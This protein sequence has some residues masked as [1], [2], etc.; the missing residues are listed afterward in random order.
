M[1]P[2][3][4]ATACSVLEQFTGSITNNDP[5]HFDVLNADGVASSCAAPKE[6]PG[7]F[8]GPTTYH[9]DS[10]TFTNN[11]SSRRC[12]TVALDGSSCGTVG[13]FSVAYLGSF[14]L[15]DLCVNY[16]ADVGRDVNGADSYS[17]EVPNGM[18]FKVLVEEYWPWQGCASYTLAVSGLPC[19]NLFTPTITPT[20]SR[21]PT[22]TATS[23]VTPTPWRHGGNN[24]WRISG[25]L[26]PTVAILRHQ[27]YT[28]DL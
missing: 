13:I 5:G 26:V 21:T 16:L 11:S 17:F 19:E 12:I 23:T 9:Y 1:S 28:G 25:R 3:S 6:C 18:S 22:S 20:F 4:S 8:G 7:L 14:N 24:E 27:S 15:N 10:Y 2:T